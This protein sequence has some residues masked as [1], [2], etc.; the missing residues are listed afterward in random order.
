[1]G[2]D[3]VSVRVA[4]FLDEVVVWLGLWNCVRPR[5]NMSVRVTVI[6]TCG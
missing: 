3:R 4:L 2:S 6:V 5:I 1:M